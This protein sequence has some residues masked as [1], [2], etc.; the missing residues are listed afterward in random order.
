MKKM[1]VIAALVVLFCLAGGALW[2][3]GESQPT[4]L[5][6]GPVTIKGE[7]VV[8]YRGEAGNMVPAH[9][10][11]KKDIETNFPGTRVVLEVIPY[12]EM[13]T[14]M[15]TACQAGAGPD[16]MNQS[17]AWTSGFMARGL[18]EPLTGWMKRFNRDIL[19]DFNPAYY[20]SVQ[21]DNELY[22][23]PLTV[24]LMELVYNN[25]MFK[26]AGL[27]RP[28][29]NWQEVFEY[30]E[31]LTK[32]NPDG[33]TRVYGFALPAGSAGNIWF[34]ILPEIWSAGGDICTPDMKTATL[35]T[36]PVKDAVRYYCDTYFKGYSLKS[37][38]ELEQS[39]IQPFFANGQVAMTIENMD[40]SYFN[41]VGKK[42]FDVGVGLWPGKNG[43]LKAGIGGWYVCMASSAKNKEG[44][45]YFI[46]GLTNAEGQA[47]MPALPAL[48]S[49]MNESQWDHPY[50]DVFK[51]GLKDYC[52]PFP[53]FENNAAAQSALL[54][55]IQ[56]VLTQRATI[57]Q[58]VEKAN[59]EIQ[60]L[61]DQQNS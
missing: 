33:T 58:A 55:M 4:E 49:A 40:F 38:M 43:P 59:R 8:W 5:G 31:K 6:T 12:D 53:D 1:T 42:L 57:D 13:A 7:V 44:G 20:R 28:P 15:M 18:L 3:G 22:A 2:A 26:E 23:V 9:E 11:V 17:V 60:E 56:S 54:N 50:F 24:N 29:R 25:D 27:T 19:K 45:A 14:R 36:Q 41:I 48:A 51:E 10:K 34:R 21:K 16:V 61:L 39:K 30:S 32:K 35:N 47:T 52:R 46:N 37:M